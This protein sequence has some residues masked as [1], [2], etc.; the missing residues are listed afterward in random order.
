M[1]I[2][3]VDNTTNHTHIFRMENGGNIVIVWRN[4]PEIDYLQVSNMGKV[5]Q[6]PHTTLTSSSGIYHHKKKEL[7]STICNGYPRIKFHSKRYSVHR[8]VAMAFIPNPENKPEVNHIDG[9]KT[10]NNV[11]NLEWVTHSENVKHAV[12]TGLWKPSD[13]IH[14]V[15][16]LGVLAIKKSILCVEDNIEFDSI[17]LA[18]RYY[19]LGNGTIQD[20]LMKHQGYVKKINKHFALV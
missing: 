9:N 13:A 20:S 19:K 5:R 12:R 6:L 16:K 10:N 4:V 11:G 1:R 8:L 15:S 3:L 2:W 7:N 17:S 18:M 14:E